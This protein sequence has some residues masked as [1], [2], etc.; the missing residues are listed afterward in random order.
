VTAPAVLLTRSAEDAAPLA[1]RLAAE[2]WRPLVWPTLE[3]R[4][5]GAQADPAGAQAVLFT[6]RHAVAATPAAPLPAFCVGAAT[7]AAARAAGFARA[8]SADG[9]A[10]ALAALVAA[11]LDPSAGPLAF[12]RGAAVAGDLAGALRARGFDVVETVVYAAAPARAAPP[13]IAAA[14][15]AGA[16]RAVT[17][18]SPRGAAAFA[19]LAGPW[20][21]GL[22]ATAAVAI[23][24][25][26]AAPLAGLGF[27][28]VAVAA[29]PDAAAMA[30]AL[31]PLRDR[32]PG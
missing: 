21:D 7:A 22:A 13:D 10:A 23:S 27:A 25:A 29:R 31:A 20:R 12:P 9:D 32:P 26:A 30:A 14:L 8:L 16:V 11:T 2:G 5:T 3:L 18:W 6:S 4:A 24:A 17:V 1:A 19:A 15:A 28:E